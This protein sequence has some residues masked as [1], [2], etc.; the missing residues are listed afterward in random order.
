MGRAA[1]IVRSTADWYRPIVALQDMAEHAVDE[2]W[3]LRNYRLREFYFATVDDEVIGVLSLQHS[4]AYIYVG[5][6]Y[7]DAEFV[8]RGYGGELLSFAARAG[9]DR[10]YRGLVL[11][12]HPDA[13]WA[14]KAYEKF[15]FRV[16]LSTRED[17]LAW[18]DGFLKPF[19]EENFALFQYDFPTALSDG[20]VRS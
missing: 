15:G 13:G 19:Y 16:R 9:I 2:E 18:N 7:L 3:A 6:I 10:G 14:V 1:E 8:G 5:Y 17:V 11:I 4:G 20:D 12:S